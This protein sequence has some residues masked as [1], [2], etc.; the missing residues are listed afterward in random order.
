MDLGRINLATVVA[1]EPYN[2]SDGSPVHNSDN[3]YHGNVT[4]RTAI[5][6]SYNVVAVKTLTEITP[7]TG[8]DYLLRMGFSELINDK[9]WD[10]I[11]PLALG[12]SILGAA[13]ARDMA[14]I[15]LHT[16]FHGG[17]APER[18]AVLENLLAEVKE[19]EDQL[20]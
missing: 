9:N 8:F 6:N 5:A 19:L 16:E 14:D 1:D 3:A 18:A 7:Q 15:F 20:F 4:I 12:G 13:M 2:Y 11:Q 17:A 10:V